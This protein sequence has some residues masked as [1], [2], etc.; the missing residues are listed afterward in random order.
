LLLDVERVHDVLHL[1]KDL[2]EAGN[3]SGLLDEL[4]R[5]LVDASWLERGDLREV[6]EQMRRGE[7]E[8][9][10]ALPKR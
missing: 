6:V 8:V 9:I 2:R 5:Q 3:T 4:Y 10:A 7:G 1:I